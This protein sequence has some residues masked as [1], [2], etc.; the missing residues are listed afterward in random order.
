MTIFD[1]VRIVIHPSHTTLD[2]TCSVSTRVIRPTRARGSDPH[3]LPGR[4]E[5]GAG[6]VT[7]GPVFEVLEPRV[8]LS[9]SDI[10]HPFL[11]TTESEYE[12]LR[13]RAEHAPWSDMKADAIS[14]S[15][16]GYEPFKIYPDS[17]NGPYHV[18]SGYID[19]GNVL[20]ASALAYILDP[21]G[22]C[23]VPTIPKA[24]TKPSG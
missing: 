10:D 3:G 19:V 17:E 6:Q 21:E 12:D 18:N 22:Y 1:S 23:W 8:L 13:A 15:N 16:A 24:G 4:R 9:S 14:V 2:D 5:A 20:S 7:A 11:I